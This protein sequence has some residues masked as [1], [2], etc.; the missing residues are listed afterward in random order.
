MSKINNIVNIKL[1]DK[2]TN[3]KG[4]IVPSTVNFFLTFATK[5]NT[6]W[7]EVRIN[8]DALNAI[9]GY[10][11]G[12]AQL[13]PMDTNCQGLRDA[14]DIWF[15]EYKFGKKSVFGTKV[16]NPVTGGYSYKFIMRNDS[17]NKKM[18]DTVSESELA[19]KTY[20]KPA[21]IPATAIATSLRAFSFI[22]T[23][24]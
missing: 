7:S 10:G 13:A 20:A 21:Y 17:I 11:K 19:T 22:P 6:E 14:N 18:I 3:A 8:L 4:V 12:N 16:K 1:L 24:R 5:L 2:S 23:K 15:N 9:R